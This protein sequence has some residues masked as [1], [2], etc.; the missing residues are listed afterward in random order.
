M[1]DTITKRLHISGLTPAIT[2]ED[3]QKR[4]SSF[5]T[6]KSLDGFG[7]LDGVGRPRKFGYITLETTVPQ[8]SKCTVFVSTWMPP[9]CSMNIIRSE[10]PQWKYME[11]D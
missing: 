2:K 9:P 6:V 8:L 11:G 5:G 4:L 3:L 1:S 10:Y 7:L